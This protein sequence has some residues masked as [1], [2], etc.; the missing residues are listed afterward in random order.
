MHVQSGQRHR[1]PLVH[2]IR[3]V[4]YPVEETPGDVSHKSGRFLEGTSSAAISGLSINWTISRPCTQ[5]F[6]AASRS[7]S[8]PGKLRYNDVSKILASLRWDVAII[9]RWS[10]DPGTKLIVGGLSMN[11]SATPRSFVGSHIR[12]RGACTRNRELHPCRGALKH[13]QA[14]Q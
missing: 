12:K 6:A 2:L 13:I 5:P 10:T 14:H 4:L 3:M 9:S 11:F 8:A 7:T 1:W